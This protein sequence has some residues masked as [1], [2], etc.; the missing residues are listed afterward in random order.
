MVGN[1]QFT[2]NGYFGNPSNA[3]I[4]EVSGSNPNANPDGNCYHD[5][6][7]TDG[8]LTSDPANIDSHNQCGQSYAGEPPSS[9]LFAE[10][11]CNSQALGPCPG[12]PTTDYPRATTI[13][14][15]PLQPQTTM[16]DPCQGVPANPWCPGNGSRNP[17]A[18]GHKDKSKAGHRR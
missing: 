7:D 16:P 3:D 13:V 1:N 17:A 10:V 5:N 6:V 11:V 9:T 8:T 12:T 4:G 18:K 14:L 15:P 2:H